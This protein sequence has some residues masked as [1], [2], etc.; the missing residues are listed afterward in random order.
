[1]KH[2]IL[3]LLAV[4]FSLHLAAQSTQQKNDSV[5][6]IVVNYMNVQEAANIY[7]MLNE[8]F[9]RAVSLDTLVAGAKRIYVMGKMQMKFESYTNGMNKYKAIFPRDSLSYGIALDSAGK[10]ATLFFDTY[11]DDYKKK[12]L[13]FTNNRLSTKL[14][15]LVD[16]ASRPYAS[17]EVNCG[18]S[19]G[20]I[21]D[22]KTYFYEYGETKRGNKQ[23]PNEHTLYEIG[24][25]TKTFTATLLADAV[26]SGKINLDDPVNKYLPDSI[27]PIQYEG[28]PATI[29]MLA[30]HT[31]GIPRMPTN[32]DA[33]VTDQANPYSNYDVNH[34][35][36]FFKNLKLTRR[37]ATA[38]EYSN[39]ALAALGVI[40]EN[41]Y[42]KSFEALVTEKI[43]KPLGMNE[44]M[45]FIHEKDS[46]RVAAGY[47]FQGK[48][49][50]P[51]NE[52]VFASTGALRSTAADML[53]YAQANISCNDPL[54]NKD[55][56]LTHTLTWDKS[57]RVGLVWELP[58]NSTSHFG[59]LTHGGA[60]G[61]YTS[62]I[63]ICPEKQLAI[64]VLSNSNAQGFTVAQ[65]SQA[66]M[67]GMLNEKL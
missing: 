40:L 39:A 66:I 65:I 43:L 57:P 15:K 12:S 54:I 61:G 60:T 30:N 3:S 20:I 64:I 35:Y 41:L 36:S 31:S 45:Q 46:A 49:N 25:I 38:Y 55:I 67:I 56:Q 8:A 14:D 21:K 9:R 18:L 52:K 44:T 58:I 10:I 37:P 27:P 22:G 42:Q 47:G 23:L 4:F 11:F 7:P 17:L 2:I 13:V 51:W 62:N 48:Y 24:S 29:K 6:Q 34:L 28:V 53:R 59:C 1:M 63:R 32:F 19:I 33:T 50:G 26:N 5:S 16:S